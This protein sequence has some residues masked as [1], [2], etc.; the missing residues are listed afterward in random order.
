MDTKWQ[1]TGSRE[2]AVWCTCV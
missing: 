1:F 2:K